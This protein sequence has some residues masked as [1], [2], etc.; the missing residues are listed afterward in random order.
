[1]KYSVAQLKELLRE[2]G[3][4]TA[5]NKTD[6]ILRLRQNDSDTFDTGSGDESANEELH[7]AEDDIV[8]E[9]EPSREARYREDITMSRELEFVRRERDLLHRELELMRREAASQNRRTENVRDSAINRHSSDLKGL[10]DFDGT[11]NEFWKW[12]QQVELLHDTYNLD[13]NDIKMLISSKLKGKAL[14]WFHSKP[15]HIITSATDLLEK[16]KRMFDRRPSK[17]AL[18]KEFERKIWQSRESFSEY[19]HDKA[20]LANRVPIDDSELIDYIIDGIPDVRLRNQARLQRF[21]EPTDLV[22]AFE[23]VSLR[24]NPKTEKNVARK[25]QQRPRKDAESNVARREAI[26]CFNCKEKAH[27]AVECEKPRATLQKNTDSQSV[28]PVRKLSELSTETH[29][30]QPSVGT[31]PYV[32]PIS[33]TVTDNE[34]RVQQHSFMAIVDTGSP[35]SLIK[36]KYVP[37]N[38]LIP[39]EKNDYRYNGINNSHLEILGMF[40]KDIKICDIDTQIRFFVVPESTMSGAA[41]LG[42]DFTSNTA[43]KIVIGQTLRVIQSKGDPEDETDN[44]ANQIRHIECDDDSTDSSKL[45]INSNAL[46]N[47]IRDLKQMYTNTYMSEK[48]Y[49]SPLN[50]AEMKICLKH[51]LPISFRAR[52]LAHTDKVKLRV[53]LDNLLKDGIIRES[54]SP[55]A[56]PIVLVKKKDGNLRLCV[57]YRELNKIT[58]RD[59]FPI[60][61]IDDHLDQLNSKRIYS[62]LDLQNGFHHVKMHESSVKYTSFITPMGQYEYLRMPFGLTNA[63][64]VF[65]R[66]VNHIFRSMI[67]EDKILIYMDDLLIATRKMKEH[68]AILNET[69]ELARHHKLKFRLD[70]CSFLYNSITYLGYT[71]NENGIQPSVANIESVVN[72]PILRNIKEVHRFVGLAS[73]FRRFISRFSMITKPLYDLLKKNTI[74]KFGAEEIN[75]FDV[76]KSYLSNKPILSIYSPVAITEL[77]CDANANGFGAILLQK[78][79]DGQF[80]PISYFSHRTSAV[81]AKYHSFELECLAVIYAI[82]RFHVYLVSIKFKIVIDC[83]SFRLT[84]A[85]QTVNPRISRWAMFL[86]QYDYEIIHRPGKRMMHVDALSRCNNILVLEGN[87]FEQNLSIKQNQD[88]DIIKIRDKL[89]KVEDKLFDL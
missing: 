84:L 59:N 10:K 32:V 57:D 25:E 83:D 54:S 73:Y 17:L 21:K 53:I 67:I 60:P 56:S 68:L 37:I 45:N 5:G 50:E 35:I 22:E 87:T 27:R 38:C 36:P 70:K 89:E 7:I 19:Y 41:L 2:R 23:N 55:Y 39:V 77:H 18:R 16:M 81:E 46:Y 1:M 78:Q 74:F 85:K 24:D 66:Y 15:E 75:A 13:D 80:K 29:L 42:R 86:Q 14:D 72:Y 33:Y 4:P 51:E 52:R 20:I 82:K 49:E 44:F 12:K 8:V 9:R 71:I 65:Q 76:L 34:S 11:G 58:I 61:L 64:R 31:E 26:R 40:E 3:L 69:F 63:P 6:L 47:A 43:M 79:K 28:N 30:I 48:E 88:P 62:C